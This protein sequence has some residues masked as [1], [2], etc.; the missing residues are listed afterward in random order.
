MRTLIDTNILVYAHD[1][2]SSHQK[3]ASDL[4]ERALAGRIEA[5]VSIQNI[6]E[7]FSVLTNRKRMKRPFTPREA[8]GICKLYLAAPEIPKLTPDEKTLS[9][10]LELARI[11]DV[12]SAL[13]FD[14]VLAA[15]MESAGVGAIYTENVTDFK[16]FSFLESMLPANW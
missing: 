15:T 9:R 8:E 1:S 16:K 2:S 6:A 4:L 12:S 3:V 10:A 7:L 5:V 14:C 11:Y 13:F